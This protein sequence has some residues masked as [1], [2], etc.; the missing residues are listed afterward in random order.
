MLLR[1]GRLGGTRL[2]SPRT[3]AHVTRT[4]TADRIDRCMVHAA[5]G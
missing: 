4:F 5:I 1:D 2:L 3:V